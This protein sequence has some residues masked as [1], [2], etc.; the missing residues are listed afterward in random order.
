MPLFVEQ[1][2]VPTDQV[3]FYAGL[4]ISISAISAAFLSPIW[5]I[6]ADKFG[7]KPMMIRAGFAMTLTM[8][9][10]AFVPNVYWLLF[11]RFL[12]HLFNLT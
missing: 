6:L 1:L 2:G 4:G 10:L 9:G 3:A 8:G 5:G 7:R 12:N 11:L